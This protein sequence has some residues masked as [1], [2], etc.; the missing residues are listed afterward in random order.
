MNDHFHA[1][2]Y[3]TALAVE[4]HFSMTSSIWQVIIKA[5]W[6][7]ENLEFGYES[8]ISFY[9]LLTCLFFFFFG[10]AWLYSYKHVDFKA[11]YVWMVQSVQFSSVTQSCL[12]LCDPVNRSM[13]GRPVH[14]NSW[15]LLNSCPSSRWCHPSISSSVVPFCS[16]PQSLPASESFPMSQLFTWDGQSTRVSA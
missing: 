1:P 5:L 16:C 14:Q 15:S 11:I 10:S 4:F 8:L 2:F 13:P 6:Q 9:C 3:S 7:V 12:I